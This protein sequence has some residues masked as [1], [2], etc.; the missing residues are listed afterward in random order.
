M[1]SLLGRFIQVV[2]RVQEAKKTVRV[3]YCR[4]IAGWLCIKSPALS[5][6]ISVSTCPIFQ[7]IPIGRAGLT[8][9]KRCSG[10]TQ[11]IPI[12]SGLRAQIGLW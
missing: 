1:V 3:R 10:P 2:L 8:A 11:D 9:F 4:E 12:F 7:Q 5:C 6:N